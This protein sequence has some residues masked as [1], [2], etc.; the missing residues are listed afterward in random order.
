MPAIRAKSKKL[1]AFLWEKLATL[2]GGFVTVFTPQDPEQRGS[3]LS[4]KIRGGTREMVASLRK[5]GVICDFREP[6]IIRVAPTGLYNS[7]ADCERFVE[8]L[9]RYAR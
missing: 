9:G 5:D 1:T 8:R 4:L 7:F 6:N 3:Q 2:P